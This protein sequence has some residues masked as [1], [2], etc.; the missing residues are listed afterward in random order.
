V[1]PNGLD[2]ARY[3]FR[4]RQECKPRLVWLRAF[5]EIYAATV[6]VETAERLLCRWPAC[7]LDMIGPDKGD[8]SLNK[9][10][11]C[12]RSLIESKTLEIALGVSK[13]QVPEALASNDIFLNTTRYES[14]GVSLLE[15]MACGLCVVS[16]NV[17]A[18]PYLID[19]EVDGLLVPPDDSESM[20][21][22]VRRI[23]TEPGL[24]GRLSLN[25]RRKAE[26]FDWGPIID[27]WE[28]L[29]REVV[30]GASV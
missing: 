30:E 18:V 6:A 8:G 22:A 24:A 12:G 9:V 3:P 5:H 7:H 25:A 26:E 29:Y 11:I 28:N 10:E 17:G 23:L 1:I 15:A 14:F 19:D 4:L 2:L 21:A 20:A 16:T 27:R 13:A